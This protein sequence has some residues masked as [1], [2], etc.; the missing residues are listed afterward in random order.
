VAAIPFASYLRIEEREL[1]AG[2]RAEPDA[3]RAADWHRLGVLRLKKQLLVGVALSV[4][5]AGVAGGCGGDEQLS[6]EAY[7][8]RLNALCEDF[9]KREQEIGEPHTVADLV[10][11][12]PRI[13]DAFEMAIADKI[14][15]LNA[16]DEI[17]DQAGRL[18]DIA[19]EQGDVLGGLIA[20]ARD[21][22]VAEVRRLASRN[23][24]LNN[25]ST[26]IARELGADACD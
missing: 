7:V 16:P 12:G 20:A 15:A 2:R 14:R 3:S 9:S 26:S 17:A 1:E 23:D 10:E 4:L 5:I 6:K 24:A 22:D 21:S 19:D 13:L 18:V 11:K 8:S 25:A